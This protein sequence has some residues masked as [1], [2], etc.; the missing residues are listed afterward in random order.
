MTRDAPRGID[1]RASA[2]AAGLERRLFIIKI[3]S[4][5]FARQSEYT[6]AVPGSGNK[7]SLFHIASSSSS[8]DKLAS[9]G[10]FMRTDVRALRF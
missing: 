2:A 9:P 4:I 10:R 3:I 8:S 6:A 5:T 1:E 7:S